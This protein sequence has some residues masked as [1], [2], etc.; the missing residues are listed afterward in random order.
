MG[1]SLA[2]G[3]VRILIVAGEPGGNI[4]ATRQQIERSWGSRVIDHHGLTEVGPVSFECW[5]APGSLHLNEAEFVCEVIDP[6]QMWAHLG[7]SRGWHSG[8]G[9]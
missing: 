6:V 1:R 2:D 9:R 8:A 4:P 5:E 3:P 7:P